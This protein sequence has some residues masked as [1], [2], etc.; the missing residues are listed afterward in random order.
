MI[1]SHRKAPDNIIKNWRALQYAPLTN[2]EEYNLV[3][4]RSWFRTDDWILISKYFLPNRHPEFLR[5]FSILDEK[6]LSKRIKCE[7]L[8]DKKN[9]DNI[10]LDL[11]YDLYYD[12][13][14]R[15]S[16]VAGKDDLI[17]KSIKKLK[18]G[19]CG[20][21]EGLEDLIKDG[22]NI[23]K[24][25]LN[26]MGTMSSKRDAAD[27]KSG[28]ANA[29]NLEDNQNGKGESNTIFSFLNWVNKDATNNLSY[30]PIGGN[31]NNFY[32]QNGMFDKS[33]FIFNNSI[34]N[35]NSNMPNAW[36]NTI[37]DGQHSNL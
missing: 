5:I 13:R 11:N 4:G 30:E 18:I 10:A 8:F 7:Y 26:N 29:G 28:P 33:N 36:T 21:N 2:L 12:K 20:F 15:A 1:F 16:G 34:S 6:M 31:T 24:I 19:K 22:Y 9:I 23:H 14:E 32:S 25:D 35:Q 27:A 37:L 17:W 3:K